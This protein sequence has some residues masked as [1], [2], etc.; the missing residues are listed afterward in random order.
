MLAASGGAPQWL[1]LAG[2]VTGAA[3]AL[4][5]AKLRNRNVSAAA[6]VAGQSLVWNGTAQQWEPQTISGGGGGGS[7]SVQSDGSTVGSRPALNYTP[8]FGILNMISDSGSAI[9]L[10]QAVD[11]SVVQSKAA[12]QSGVVLS[13]FSAS[14]STSAY[15]C[16]LS[17][18]L[19]AYSTGMVIN[20]RPDVTGVGGNVTLNI[21]T[22]GAK[23][24]KLADGVTNPSPGDLAAGRLYAVWYDGAAF[25]VMSA[26]GG[27]GGGG[28]ASTMKDVRYFPVGSRDQYGNPAPAVF[29]NAN[30]LAFFSY[31]S[32]ALSL[33]QLVL[34]DNNSE[35]FQIVT[36]VPPGL[37]NLDVSVDTVQADGSTGQFKLN[38]SAGCVAHG[39][40]LLSLAYNAATNVT[41]TYAA[42]NVMNR[43]TAAAVNVSGCAEG[44]LL[45]VQVAR[46]SSDAVT[47]DVNITGVR[48]SMTRSLN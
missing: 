22:L 34:N 17:P 36:D 27:G 21:D 5:V 46:D 14:A 4:T 37:T 8:G 24:V 41:G 43:V 10:Q 15:T 1:D 28:G 32:G 3:G 11:T 38:V 47:S 16:G 39:E 7:L 12:A 40:N 29:S 48:L 33:T 25:R 19:G 45:R 2:D 31:G 18:V 20:W 30:Q 23:S 6:P 44:E 42:V 26:A 9:V 13:C 35:A